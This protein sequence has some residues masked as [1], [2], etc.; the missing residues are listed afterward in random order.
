MT[1]SKKESENIG[2]YGQNDGRGVAKRTQTRNQR[3]RTMKKK[4]H[5]ERRRT[6]VPTRNKKECKTRNCRHG[7]TKNSLPKT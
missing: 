2:F 6:S 4:K 5:R 7:K 3:F 1:K